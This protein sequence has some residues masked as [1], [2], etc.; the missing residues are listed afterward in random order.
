MCV[1]AREPNVGQLV[2]PHERLVSRLFT[3]PISYVRAKESIPHFDQILD[4]SWNHLPSRPTSRQHGGVL[5]SSRTNK[6]SPH[7][8]NPWLDVEVLFE[9]RVQRRVVMNTIV[10][11]F[12]IVFVVYMLCTPNPSTWFVLLVLSFGFLGLEIY[13][14]DHFHWT[15]IIFFVLLCFS[16]VA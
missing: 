10:C 14:F 5:M 15:D 11:S 6:S 9:D 2:F 13:I 8:R 4:S 1:C 7:W 16:N 3:P 12:F